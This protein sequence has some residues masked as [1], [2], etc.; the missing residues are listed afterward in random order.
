[1]SRVHMRHIRTALETQF[2][3]LV[4][5]DDVQHSAEAQRTALLSR[6][7][8]AYTLT[9]VYGLELVEAALCV[10]DGFDDNGIDALYVNGG[11]LVVVQSK[12]DADGR[13]SPALGDVQ[14]FVQGF[15]DLI[16]DRFDFF[17][18]AIKARKPE[19]DRILDDPNATLE[20][21]LIHTGVGTLSRHAVRVF[22]DLQA[23][24]NDPVELVTWRHLRQEDIHRFVSGQLAAQGISFDVLLYEWGVTSDPFAAYY[25]QVNATDV[26]EWLGIHGPQLF[27][28]NLRKLIPDSDVN[29]SIVQSVLTMPE[30]FWYLNNGVTA[31]CDRIRKKPIGGSDRKVGEFTCE[32]VSIVNGAQTVGSITTARTKDPEAVSKARV[33]VRFISLENCPEDFP[34]AVTRATNTQ[35][36][37]E[38]RDFVA[39]DPEQERLKTELL[40]EN[41]KIYTFK[42]G[43]PDPTAEQGCSVVDATIALACAS[44]DPMMSVQAKREIGRLW[45]D[46]KKAPYTQI[47]NPSV[48]ALKLWRVVQVMRVVE[49]TLKDEQRKREGRSR[50]V[51]VHG[52]RLILHLV[53]RSLPVDEFNDADFGFD[54]VLRRVK[55]KS[56][57]VLNRLAGLVEEQYPT[58]Y[59]ASLFKNATKCKT[60]VASFD[61]A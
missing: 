48:T 59:V 7:L 10:T 40:L 23:D 46:I 50:G 16:N 1:M 8:A 9:Q 26:A 31:L 28:K 49:Q 56:I 58:S 55:P 35:N 29:E 19:I 12:W 18:D 36:R 14:K 43:E 17:N 52:N 54:T 37:I 20:L 53:F 30:R 27:A 5:V 41:H 25:G 22:E 33:A 4:D 38:N 39:L 42:T 34:A 11:R 21:I 57:E 45:V 60:L 47:F 6:A 15:N 44:R 3:G 32:G 2:E 61:H 24:L 13:G 51:A